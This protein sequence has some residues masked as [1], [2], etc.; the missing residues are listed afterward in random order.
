MLRLPG[1]QFYLP[2]NC[3]KKMCWHIQLAA[4]AAALSNLKLGLWQ[5][6]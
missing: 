2:D 4:E 5:P 1:W 3:R 6:R